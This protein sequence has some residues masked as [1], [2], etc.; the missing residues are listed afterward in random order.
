LNRQSQSATG[1]LRWA[2][3]SKVTAN[4]ASFWQFGE[5]IAIGAIVIA[6]A[7]NAET[8]HLLFLNLDR[9]IGRIR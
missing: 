2:F 7:T 6:S 3:L 9:N 4:R 8:W 5:D 1:P